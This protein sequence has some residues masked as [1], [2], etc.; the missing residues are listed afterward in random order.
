MPRFPPVVLASVFAAGL[1]MMCLGAFLFGFEQPAGWILFAF[2]T[3]DVLAS[4]ILFVRSQDP[5]TT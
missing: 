2:G 1:L 3:F 4:T 5:P